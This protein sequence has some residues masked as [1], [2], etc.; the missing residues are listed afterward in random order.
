M[1]V[2][3][4]AATLAAQADNRRFYYPPDIALAVDSGDRYLSVSI[5]S[6]YRA[7][8]LDTAIEDRFYMIKQFS[9]HAA[10]SS[11]TTL[12]EKD[13]YDAT[14]NL[15]NQGDTTQKAAAELALSN[16]ASGKKEGW[17]L[18]MENS[19]EKVLAGSATI[20]NQVV[21][22][23]YEPTPSSG[24]TCNATQGTS[25]AY[26]VS[27]FDA[28]PMLDI[29]GNGST[30]AADRVIQL[31]IGSIP[32]TPTVIDTLDS[33]PTVWVGPERLDQVDT[34]VEAVRTYWIEENN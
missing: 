28:S 29:D 9:T 20:Q 17:Y 10:P 33:K 18:R 30:N 26:L 13:L 32:A 34:D 16:S 15:I 1:S 5:G 25:R 12:T 27:L 19:G 8:P 21:F 31:Q 4:A 14:A 6:G 2:A 23:T 7:H 22:T 11:Y 3:D 24:G